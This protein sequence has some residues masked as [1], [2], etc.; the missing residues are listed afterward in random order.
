M[1]AQ[2]TILEVA[3]EFNDGAEYFPIPYDPRVFYPTP[4]PTERKIKRVFLAS[5]HD[6]RT[7]GTDRFLYALS[8][9]K[10]PLEIKTI[11]Y[12]KD[13]EK[14]EKLAKKLGLKTNFIEKVPHNE[15]NNLYWESDIVLGSFGIGQL[16]TVAIEAMACGRPL[17]HHIRKAFYPSCLLEE[18]SKAKYVVDLIERLL[19]SRKEAMKRVQK[20]LEYV[21]ANHSSIV[22]A[23]KLAMI[24]EKLVG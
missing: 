11:R 7:K 20:Q 21:K 15:I 17:V 6:F 8:S 4:L 16:D 14:A 10:I 22:L 18:F 9:I 3:R 24:Y 5:A 12:G 19:T 2:P 13:V 23:E 1:V